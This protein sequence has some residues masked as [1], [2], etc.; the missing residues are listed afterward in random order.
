MP[1]NSRKKGKVGESEFAKWLTKMGYASKR[2]QQHKG[3]PDSP[4]VISTDLPV[5]VHWEVKRRETTDFYGF[6]AQAAEEAGDDQFPIVA[7]RK[8]RQ[9]WAVIM[10]A[11]EFF[12]MLEG[13]HMQ[14]YQD[15][16]YDAGMEA[17]DEG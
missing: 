5:D 1:I 7:H 17:S 12:T 9:R 8:N 15:G 3:G 14:G 2:G 4:D 10:D 16:L 13:V 11:E 6:L